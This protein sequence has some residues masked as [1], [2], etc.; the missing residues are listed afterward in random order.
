MFWD[1]FPLLWWRYLMVLESF[2][3]VLFFL[4]LWFGIS[5]FN[6]LFRFSMPPHC[7]VIKYFH[8]FQSIVVVIWTYNINRCYQSRTEDICALCQSPNIYDNLFN[9]TC[10]HGCIKVLALVITFAAQESWG[11]LDLYGFMIHKRM[12]LHVQHN[13]LKPHRFI[14]QYCLLSVSPHFK[15]PSAS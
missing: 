9:T 13:N 7:F 11:I 1:K 4:A 10:H 15:L 12:C 5:V 2:S 8:V 3:D 14:V 6:V